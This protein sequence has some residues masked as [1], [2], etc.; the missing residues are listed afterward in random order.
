ICREKGHLS[1]KDIKC[2]VCEVEEFA[3]ED[4]TNHNHIEALNLLLFI[5][6]LKFQ[7]N[8]MD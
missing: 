6:R 2:I 1:K 4:D 8:R 7:C 3:W 5:Y